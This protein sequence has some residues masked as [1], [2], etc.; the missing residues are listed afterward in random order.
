MSNKLMNHID[1]SIPSKVWDTWLAQIEFLKYIP[2]DQLRF[3]VGFGYYLG[4]PIEKDLWRV[5]EYNSGNKNAALKLI[6]DYNAITENLP[7]KFLLKEYDKNATYFSVLHDSSASNPS[8]INSDVVRM[9]VDVANMYRFGILSG[10]KNVLEIGGGYGHLA[11]F[12]LSRKVVDSYY[13]IDFMQVLDVVDRWVGSTDPIYDVYRYD[14]FD[15]LSSECLERPGLHLISNVLLPN[16]GDFISFDLMINM[17]SFCEMS[18]AQVEQYISRSNFDYNI[19][20]SN[21]RDK[22]MLNDE[23][24]SLSRTFMKYGFIWPDYDTSNSLLLKKKVIILSRNGEGFNKLD[25]NEIQGITGA[26]MNS[27]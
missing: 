20:Y 26:E 4:A 17:N 25:I 23:L 14:K 10:L 19:L 27:M 13:V 16:I 21:N 6:R 3:H 24:D 9:Q 8:L 11:N 1:L 12:F 2:D 18:Q 5:N 15:N 7:E 22:Q